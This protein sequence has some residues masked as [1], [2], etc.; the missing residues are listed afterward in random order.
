MRTVVVTAGHSNKQGGAVSPDGYYRE[1]ALAAEMRNLIVIRLRA[2]GIT[3]L[4][5]GVG[6]V[7]LP[8]TEAI[9]IARNHVGPEL[10]IHLNAGPVDKATGV[11][12]Y[13]LPS[14]ARL[15]QDLAQAVARVLGLPLR[16]EEGWQHPQSS[17]H[18]KLGICNAGAVLLELCFISNKNDLLQLLKHFEKVADALASVLDYWAGLGGEQRA[19]NTPKREPSRVRAIS[20]SVPEGGTAAAGARD[21][22]QF[23]ATWSVTA[24]ELP[25]PAATSP[26]Q[27]GADSRKSQ[28]TVLAATFAQIWASVVAWWQGLDVRWIYAGLMIGLTVLALAYLHRQTRMGEVRARK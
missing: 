13:S 26:A 23:P 10:E 3:V 11:E 5:D 4:T 1:E 25:R 22:A 14:Q 8:L 21:V 27:P 12:A 19:F 7:N 15:A 28:Q 2:K 18:G 24:P 9:R 6:A 20:P 17:Q 16:G